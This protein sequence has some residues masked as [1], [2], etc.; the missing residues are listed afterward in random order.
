MKREKFAK[1]VLELEYLEER[2][3]PSGLA[4]GAEP[5]FRPEGIFLTPALNS[6]TGGPSVL[7]PDG[8]FLPPGLSRPLH[9]LPPVVTQTEDG[10][11]FQPLG[12]DN[13]L[14]VTGFFG[15]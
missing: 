4:A 12:R 14:F 1:R 3:A 6:Q 13:Y 5:H 2:W 9:Q 7:M 10:L 8:R 15:R 11:A